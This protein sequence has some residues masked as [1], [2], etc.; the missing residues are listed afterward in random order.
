MS[1]GNSDYVSDTDDDSDD[2]DSDDDTTDNDGTDDDLHDD[3]GEDDDEGGVYEL[4]TEVPLV[5]DGHGVGYCAPV[6]IT[7]KDTDF[8]VQ[9]QCTIFWLN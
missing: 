8:I 5:G 9:V 4:I 7:I 3:G 2:N 1:A 6:E